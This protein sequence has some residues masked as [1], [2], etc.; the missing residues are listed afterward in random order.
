MY[1]FLKLI[2]EAKGSSYK[3]CR[4]IKLSELTTVAVTDHFDRIGEIGRKVLVSLCMVDMQF[5]G[6]QAEWP[7][8]AMHLQQDKHITAKDVDT[9]SVIWCF[10]R[11]IANTDMHNGNLYFFY[12]A[13]GA[14]TLAAV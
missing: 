12:S 7:V 2:Y 9:I 13:Q 8:I 3:I 5:V 4:R 6:K 14:F 10:G 11:L 1:R